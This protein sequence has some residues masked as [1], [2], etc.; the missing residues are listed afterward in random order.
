MIEAMRDAWTD[1]R[2]DDLNHRVDEGFKEMRAEF[3]AVRMESRTEFAAVRSE[4]AAM[5][6]T[7]LQI[8]V[9]G[10][11]V[12]LVGFAGTIATIISQA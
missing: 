1:P 2:L 7:T 5:H 12:M 6:R 9:G 3:R 8:V 4:M 11:G 10:F